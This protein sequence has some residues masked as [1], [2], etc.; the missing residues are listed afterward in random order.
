MR[1]QSAE[2]LEPNGESRPGFLAR[3]WQVPS[4]PDLAEGERRLLTSN[5]VYNPKNIRPQGIFDS[6][7]AIFM[8]SGRAWLTNERLIFRANGRQF[9]RLTNI[10][11]LEIPL[12]AI[13]TVRMP[14]AFRP[15][16]M[17]IIEVRLKDGTKHDFQIRPPGPWVE[18]IAGLLSPDA[19]SVP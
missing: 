3:F 5:A 2:W 14:R 1:R 11:E 7:G 17:D 10:K 12:S 8:V 6:P 15:S 18:A 4:E 9:M 16:R 19:M 13:N